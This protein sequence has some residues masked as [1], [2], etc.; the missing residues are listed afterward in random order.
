MES[1]VGP[2]NI[3]QGV[4]TKVT[5]EGTIGDEY[6]DVIDVEGW[7]HTPGIDSKTEPK[8]DGPVDHILFFCKIIRLQSL[9]Y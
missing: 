9:V 1:F 5:W 6:S 7:L 8:Q 3:F 2:C 4:Q